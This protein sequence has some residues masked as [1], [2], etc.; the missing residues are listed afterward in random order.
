MRDYWDERRP[1]ERSDACARAGPF[2]KA[3]AT[4][5][6]VDP[7]GAGGRRAHRRGHGRA[8]GGAAADRGPQRPGVGSPAARGRQGRRLLVDRRR[9]DHGQGPR[10]PRR[11]GRARRERR[12]RRPAAARRPVQG[13][14]RRRQPLPVLQRLQHV[15]AVAAAE[16]QEPD[17][18]RRRPAPAGLVRHRPRLVHGGNDEQPRHRLRRGPRA[19]PGHR[20]GHDV[21][22]RPDRSGGPSSPATATTRRP[23]AASTRSPAGP[24]GRRRDRSTRTPTPSPRGS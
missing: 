11:D 15:E 5:V 21:P 9:A 7:P 23:S 14:H 10:R 1:A 19:E 20:D 2:V 12:P 22:A 17:G 16:P 18:P 3:S 8:A 4:P 24:T 6:D 13:R